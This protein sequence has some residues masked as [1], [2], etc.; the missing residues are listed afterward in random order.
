MAF[1]GNPWFI[2]IAGGII[3]G[4]AVAYISR[5]LVSKLGGKNRRPGIQMAHND[6]VQRIRTAIASKQLPP[7]EH[8]GS[9]MRTAARQHGLSESDLPSSG[10][11]ADEIISEIYNNPFL[12][13]PQKHDYAE[14]VFTMRTP[15][16]IEVSNSSSGV[17]SINCDKGRQD[18]SFI[19][20]LVTFGS[21]VQA[22]LGSSLGTETLSKETVRSN[23]WIMAI[24][25]LI[26]TFVVLTVELYRNFQELKK[27]KLEF[28]MSQTDS[29]TLTQTAEEDR[30]AED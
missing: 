18:I 21:V 9:F 10:T 5:F 20:G 7:A 3:S 23:L 26:P 8:F 17:Q 24:A 25:I 19:L 6:V 28:K 11:I 14:F 2:G 4:L 13:D 1:F 22:V 16:Y 27:V 12:T 29:S 15:P 30:E